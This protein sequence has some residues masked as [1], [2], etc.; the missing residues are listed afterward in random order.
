MLPGQY[1]CSIRETDPGSG[2]SAIMN[3]SRA[4]QY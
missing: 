2:Q 1:V 4:A 3:G